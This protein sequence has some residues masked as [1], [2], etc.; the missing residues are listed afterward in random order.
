MVG[1][2]PSFERKG[3]LPDV[4]NESDKEWMEGADFYVLAHGEV[5]TH[6]DAKFTGLDIHLQ[7]IPGYPI[8]DR[9]N[10]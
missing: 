4:I 9:S 7:K 10:Q 8:L 6:I 2:R 3:P 5:S 1:K